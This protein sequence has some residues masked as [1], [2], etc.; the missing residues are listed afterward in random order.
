MDNSA[1]IK[2]TGGMML[3]GWKMLATI[4][5]ICNSALLSKGKQMHCPGCDME[6]V[7]ET[8]SQARDYTEVAS[9]KL[10]PPPKP[11]TESSPKVSDLTTDSKEGKFNYEE[12]RKEYSKKNGN[13]DAVSKKLGERMMEGWTLLGQTCTDS[14][15]RNTPLMRDRRG[16]M[17]C[18]SCNVEYIESDDAYKGIVPRPPA[19]SGSQKLVEDSLQGSM[20]SKVETSGSTPSAT[21]DIDD[22]PI[23]DMS[24]AFGVGKDDSPANTANE[25]SHKISRKLMQGWALLDKTCSSAQCVNSVPLVRD[26]NKQVR[27]ILRYYL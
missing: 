13:L 10:P 25:I 7:Y 17:I 5:P 16:F 4:C 6:V 1:T 11:S 24:T 9:S 26:K 18:V 3:S 12:A 15:C 8:S 21:F 22:V 27:S 19:G 2:R 23:L 20:S 14:G